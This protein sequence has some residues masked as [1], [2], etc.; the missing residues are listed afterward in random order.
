MLYFLSGR[1]F[2][3]VAKV[4]L[5]AIDG[6]ANIRIS[7]LS[8]KY[9]KFIVAEINSGFV[10]SEF[11]KYFLLLPLFIFLTS[12]SLIP[13]IITLWLLVVKTLANAEPKA[14]VPIKPNLYF[15]CIIKLYI[16]KCLI[17]EVKHHLLNIFSGRSSRI[18]THNTRGWSPL[19]YHW[20]ILLFKNPKYYTITW[21]KWKF[22]K[23]Y[24]YYIKKI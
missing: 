15:F 23:K 11:S 22:K 16:K 10:N 6:K 20:T 12:C 17:Y 18:R 19:F 3:S 24:F 2:F 1:I 7:E 9:S 21:T 4:S 14:P 8:T 13:Y 5:I